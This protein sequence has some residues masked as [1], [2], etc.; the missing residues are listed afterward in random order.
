MMYSVNNT[1]QRAE[2]GAIDENQD[3]ERNDH[4]MNMMI[5]CDSLAVVY[6]PLVAVR[7]QLKNEAEFDN[8][9]KMGDQT[10]IDLENT[11]D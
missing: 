11:D 7:N 3:N 6:Y 1:N 4:M 8:Q 2:Y 5:A 10:E 9:L